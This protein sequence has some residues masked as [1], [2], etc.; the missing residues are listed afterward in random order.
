MKA[1]GPALAFAPNNE[2]VHETAN[3]LIGPIG[4]G[5]R[6]RFCYA[7]LRYPLF[8]G[9]LLVTLA[10]PFFYNNASVLSVETPK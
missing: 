3:I 4:Q 9:R 8:C 2:T 6:E 7:F 1:K 5:S 10:R